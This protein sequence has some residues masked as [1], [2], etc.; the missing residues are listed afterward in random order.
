MENKDYNISLFKP[1]TPYAKANSRLVIWLVVIWAI[2][3]YGFQILLKVIEKPTPEEA[4][5][6]YASVKDK[7]NDGTAT[8]IEKQKYV[9]STLSVLGKSVNDEEKQVLVNA[10]NTTIYEIADT[11]AS[12]IMA[13]VGKIQEQKAIINELG[14]DEYKVE[15][16]KL[17]EVETTFLNS[18]QEITNLSS[19]DI[20]SKL[21][22]FYLKSTPVEKLTSEEKT[23]LDAIMGKYLIHNQSILTDIQFLGFPFHYFYTAVFLLV[24]FVGLCLIYTLKIQNLNKKFNI[25]E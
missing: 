18:I 10:V 13:E 16:R 8:T 23:S 9:Y 22:P 20:R 17:F 21:L 3:I 1:N 6:I 11:N 12:N 19:N 24:L 2:S 5:T 4:F 25:Q 15:R 14:I 7:V